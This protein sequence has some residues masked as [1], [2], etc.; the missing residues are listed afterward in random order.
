MQERTTVFRSHL[1][2]DGFEQESI[3][4]R[5]SGLREHTG[6]AGE[7]NPLL[8]VRMRMGAVVVENQMKM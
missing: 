8:K 6:S 5:G 4:R 7:F 3:E 2:I 1:V